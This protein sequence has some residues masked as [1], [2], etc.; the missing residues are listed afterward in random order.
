MTPG[1]RASRTG[2]H[3]ATILL[4]DLED[5][6][7]RAS[8]AR[9]PPGA[10]GSET[11]TSMGSTVGFCLWFHGLLPQIVMPTSATDRVLARHRRIE[12]LD[13]GDRVKITVAPDSRP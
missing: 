10:Q 8:G 6:G 5:A 12:R 7:L 13:L 9:E 1:T 4:Q 2:R 11:A 3:S